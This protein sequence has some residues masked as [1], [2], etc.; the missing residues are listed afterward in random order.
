MSNRC[1]AEEL[2]DRRGRLACDFYLQW[3]AKRMDTLR[4]SFRFRSFRDQNTYV[5]N[6]CYR[7]VEGILRYPGRGENFGDSAVFNE[8]SSLFSRALFPA[9][10]SFLRLRIELQFQPI[11]LD[12]QCHSFHS[13]HASFQSQ[14]ECG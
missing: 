2:G 14:P 9:I 13:P 1:N 4:R 6:P 7:R 10:L 8:L 11:K 5:P 12:A 3:R